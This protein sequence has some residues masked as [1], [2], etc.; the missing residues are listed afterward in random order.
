MRNK[1]VQMVHERQYKL[2]WLWGRTL[3]QFG[4]IEHGIKRFKVLDDGRFSCCLFRATW[5]CDIRKQNYLSR[6]QWHIEFNDIMY[7][8]ESI[9]SS[10]DRWHL[11]SN[12]PMRK[13]GVGECSLKELL[14]ASDGFDS[15]IK[16]VTS[17]DYQSSFEDNIL[18]NFNRY[19]YK[20]ASSAL[21][22]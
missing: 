6:L 8:V 3:W 9:S 2:K 15:E 4:W 1:R 7:R 18:L 22:H 12:R 10:L 19:W 11:T 16:C 13:G 14:D 21:V 17:Q 5:V 20:I